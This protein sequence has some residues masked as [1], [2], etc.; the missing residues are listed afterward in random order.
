MLKRIR[1][2]IDSIVY[3]G[4]KPYAPR[5]PAKG[6]RWLGPLPDLLDRFL[7]GSA[8]KDPLYLSN[9]TI[10]QRVRLALLIAVPCVI[11]AGGVLLLLS[12]IYQASDTGP[13]PEPTAAI[14]A[15]KLLPNLDHNINIDT[16]KDVQVLDAHI[17]REGGMKAAGTVKNNTNRQIHT[18]EIILNLTDSGGSHLG[19]V[20][21]K[22]DD[23]APNAMVKFQVPIEQKDATFAL[24]R[25]VITQ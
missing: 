8:P 17:E 21:A 10:E 11:L 4:L 18:T 9:R 15:A 3:A 7:S 13:P 25:E 14:L 16:N 2:F 23:L 12:N 24:V 5:G 22:V 20:S 19:A 1:Q 6:K